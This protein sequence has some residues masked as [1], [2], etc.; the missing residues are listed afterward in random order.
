M[1]M[2]VSFIANKLINLS[3]KISACV[4]HSTNNISFYKN[5]HNININ[6]VLKIDFSVL[7]NANHEILIN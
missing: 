5:V 6:N 1:N 3:R 4:S 7:C 2:H